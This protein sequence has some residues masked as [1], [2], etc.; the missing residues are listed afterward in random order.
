MKNRKT[1]TKK[2]EKS[3]LSSKRCKSRNKV[4]KRGEYP[5]SADYVKLLRPE[6]VVNGELRKMEVGAI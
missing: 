1:F 5:V 2:K 4:T 3:L 6:Y